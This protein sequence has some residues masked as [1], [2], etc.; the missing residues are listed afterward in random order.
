[1]FDTLGVFQSKFGSFGSGDGQF[2]VIQRLASSDGEIYI[3]EAAGDRVQV[4]KSLGGAET[5]FFG[6]RETE[7]I[8]A[9]TPDGGVAIPTVDALSPGNL[10]VDGADSITDHI[11]GM[12]IAIEA[13]APFYVNAVTGNP[14]NFIN[15]SDDN[16]IKVAMGNRTKYGATGGEA[17]DWTH[18]EATLIADTPDDGPFDIDIGEIEET[19][20]K[21][22]ESSTVIL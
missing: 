9:G 4:F 20:T 17:F 13:L 19:I 5:E 18:D 12:R 15:L 21:L 16:L 7:K 3:T 8:T 2:N 1:M 11:L 6:F 14:F 22:E 10:F